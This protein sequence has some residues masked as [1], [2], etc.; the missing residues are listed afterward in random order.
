[1]T[2]TYALCMCSYEGTEDTE[3]DYLEDFLTLM[4]V[5]PEADKVAL[6]H[7]LE[8]MFIGCTWQGKECTARCAR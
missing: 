6:G 7:Q 8:N 1:M 3:Y 5:I 4:S 2:A